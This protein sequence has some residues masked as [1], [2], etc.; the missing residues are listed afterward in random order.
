MTL[1]QVNSMELVGGDRSLDLQPGVNVIVGPI[2]TGK[3]TLVKLLRALFGNVPSMPPEVEQNVTSI[4]A[5]VTIGD[6]P[7]NIMRR[8][9]TTDTALVEIVNGDEALMLP[10][11][12]PTAT[13]D[14]TYSAWMLQHL[15][16]P[17]I[18]VPAAPTRP[19]SEPTSVSVADYLNYSFLRGDEI[20]NCVFGHTNAFRDI[21]RKYV[22]EIVYG[23]Y[24]EGIAELQSELRSIET[25]LTFLRGEQAT[26]KRVFE[27]TEL[28]SIEAVRVALGEREREIARLIQD[29]SDL[30]AATETELGTTLLRQA[31]GEATADLAS[32]RM[33]LRSAKAQ[34][35]DLEALVVQLEAQQ[36]RIVRA[37][38]AEEAL[39]DF[40]FV[41]CPRC[42]Q[43]LAAERGL[44]DRC[45]LCL[46]PEPQHAH[47]DGLEAERERLEEQIR[48][49]IE[50]L[51]ARR[52]S[53]SEVEVG[54]D[55][56]ARQR[57]QLAA[58]L[59]QVTAA[60]VSDRQQS[61]AE[62]AA[63]R[64]TAAAEAA[65]FRDYLTIL[66]R[67]EASEGRISELSAKRTSLREQLEESSAR[68]RAGQD[69]VDA[70]NARF[71]EY[72]R[73]LEVPSFG[74]ELTAH[75]DPSTYLP[76]VAG[77]RFETLSS[78]GLQVLVNVAHALAHH[79]VAIDR[80]LRLPGLLVLDGPS[81]NVGTEGF[82]AQR[83]V[84]VYDLLADVASQYSSS[85]QI[86]VVDNTIP[87]RGEEWVRLRLEE[88]DRLVRGTTAAADLDGDVSADAQ[89]D[90]A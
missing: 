65:K 41:I 72:V 7:F 64:A 80:G 12:R 46:Q 6:E 60:Y 20:D 11:S 25:E 83:L 17:Q 71:L 69:N 55:G 22:F 79:T 42:G 78:Q 24:D 38:L 10:A 81:S 34:L 85:L 39:V 29:E 9:V 53:L 5:S 76:V 59:E 86:I 62:A 70:L 14:L 27:G 44:E 36:A 45:R 54:L 35:Q 13:R 87:E 89:R 50:L 31:I 23:L 33:Q 4:R 19:E 48:E 16:L 26:T 32:R 3:S 28:E 52:H 1:L 21:K 90:R 77:R 47:V 2:A 30:A 43:D 63:A 74:E 40:E 61:I 51:D 84:D 58:Q 8:L 66:E 75:I 68:L 56:A 57:A 49:T 88:D 67:A 15:D 18:A 37:L 82:D 73:R